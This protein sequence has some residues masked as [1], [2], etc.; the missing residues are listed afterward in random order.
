MTKLFL[1]GV[2]IIGLVVL[3][4]MIYAR[5]HVSTTTKTNIESHMSGAPVSADLLSDSDDKNN[6]E[7]GTALT[8]VIPPNYQTALLAGGCF[9]CV[10]ADLEKVNGV[11]TVESGYAGGTTKGPTYKNYA[12]GGHREVV[13]VTYDAN[14][15]TYGQLVEYM[16]KHADPT[17][18]DGSFHDRG[19]EYSPAVYYKTEA[20]RADVEAIVA[21]LD[22][23]G[24][25]EK[26][27]DIYIEPWTAFWPAE[28]YHQDYYLKSPW[29]YKYYRQ[30]SGRTAFIE[31]HWGDESDRYVVP[32][33]QGVPVSPETEAE[34]S[35]ETKTDADEA[36]DTTPW[37]SYVKPSDA[38]L[39]QTLDPLQYKVT[40]EEGTER[41]FTHAYASN[42][43]DGI[44]V[45]ILSGEPL[46]SSTHKF[47][48]GTGWPS[49]TR[50]IDPRFVSLHED[51]RFFLQRT[52]VRSVHGDNHLGHVFNDAPQEL[53][54]IRYCMNGVSLR[55]V[56]KAEMVDAGYEDYLYLFEE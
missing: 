54:G 13:L 10:E 7:Q 1:I 11:L 38:I 16:L 26:P 21:H 25:Y 27:I 5:S 51:N 47:D 41:A 23:L 40:Q 45:D 49:F 17:D 14:V 9:W 33:N 15:V 29:K 30:A 43:E 42:Y 35:I 3:A 6:T 55:F 36:A 12:D 44:Y 18:K 39:K 20:E 50:P 4:Y 56:P 37:T 32:I 34:T 53:G 2:I 8:A 24:V 22:S 19:Y 46:F 31:K 48:S 28:E 52:E